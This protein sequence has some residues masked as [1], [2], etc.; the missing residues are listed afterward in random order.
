MLKEKEIKISIIIPVFNEINTIEKV[1]EKVLRISVEK[2][3]II[4]DDGSTDGTR[5]LL[6]KISSEGNYPMIKVLFHEKNKGKG[7]AIR[8]A[9]EHAKGEIVCFQ[10]A[11]LEYEPME[12]MELLKGFEDES[13]DAVYGSRF[14]KENPSIYK[15]FLWG[16][17][18]LT[19]FINFLYKARITDSYTCYKLIKMELAKKLRLESNGFEIEAEISA[20]LAKSKRKILELPI[21]YNPRRIE[22]GKKIRFRDALKGFY[23]ILKVK[24]KN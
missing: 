23:T 24:F 10:D 14:L 5:E 8:T 18:L 21:S 19:F 9:L 4:V 16:N 7:A 15:T 17:K 2:E 11:D 12:I 13:I 20:K 3:I 22:E 6:E 1:L